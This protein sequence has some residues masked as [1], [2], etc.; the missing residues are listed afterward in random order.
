[1]EESMSPFNKATA[2]AIATAMTTLAG[3]FWAP[4][5]DVRAAVNTLI[6]A[7]LVYLVPN[8]A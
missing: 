2:A 4:A 8:E 3:S 5:P 7:G 1:M 6:V